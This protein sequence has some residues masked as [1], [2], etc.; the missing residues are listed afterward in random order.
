[1]ITLNAVKIAKALD[2]TPTAIFDKVID[3]SRLSP[4]TIRGYHGFLSTVFGYAVKTGEIVIN[5]CA[6]CTLPKIEEKEHKILSIADTQRFLQ[7]LDEH[8]ELKYRAFFNIAIYGGFRRG[9]I[10]A[11]TWDDIDF[12]N[13]MVHIRRAVHWSK[14]KG[15]YYTAPKTK[16][17][18]RSVKMTDRVML[19]L[20]QVQDEQTEAK[21]KYGTYWNN[22]QELVFTTDNGSQMAMGTPYTFLKKFCEEYD[23]PR[24][25]VHSIVF[26]KA[27]MIFWQKMFSVVFPNVLKI[28][29]QCCRSVMK[30]SFL[31]MKTDLLL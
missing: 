15:Y 10:L 6:N 13:N 3:D 20:K 8:A 12:D 21:Y 27:G 29:L 26:V 4:K 30:H 1:M 9:E 2:K 14:S 18:K 22:P 11:L 19:I 23:L 17:S 5:P 25:S 7:L 28:L 31:I 16:K 24:V